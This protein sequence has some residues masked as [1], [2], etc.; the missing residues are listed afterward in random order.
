MKKNIVIRFEPY[1]NINVDDMDSFDK[2][3][4]DKLN[5]VFININFIS[6]KEYCPDL[7]F[8]SYSGEENSSFIKLGDPL[9]Y[10]L[11]WCYWFLESYMMYEKKISNGKQ[12]KSLL[13]KLFNKIIYEYPSLIDYIRE[14]GNYLKKNQIKILKKLDFPSNRLYAKY[15]NDDEVNY[16]F[17][18]I[19]KQ[20]LSNYR[21]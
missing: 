12:L 11:A 2:I 20:I 14:Y 18:Y 9:G 19:N 6:A 10:C 4:Y 8:Q 16:V 17:S 1:G 3:L 13:N 21:L 5:K 15:F 7:S